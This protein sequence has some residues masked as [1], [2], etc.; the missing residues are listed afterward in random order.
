M[1]GP[2]ASRKTS[3]C[4]LLMFFFWFE[5]KPVLDVSA[6]GWSLDLAVQI[7]VGGFFGLI[8]SLNCMCGPGAVL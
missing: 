8:P 5:T 6:W 1:C 4:T 2:G 3:A 7:L